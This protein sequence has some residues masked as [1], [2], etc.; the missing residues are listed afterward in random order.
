MDHPDRKINKEVAEIINITEQMNLTNIHTTFHSNTA[1]Y[2]F[3][4]NMLNILQDRPE[5]GHK[6]SNYKYIENEILCTISD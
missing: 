5:L 4:S 6:T 3:P 1:Q 2:A